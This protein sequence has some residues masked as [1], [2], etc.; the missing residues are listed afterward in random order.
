MVKHER[1]IVSP[2]TGSNENNENIHRHFESHRTLSEND[3]ISSDWY[4]EYQT[5]TVQVDRPNKMDFKRSNSQYDNHIRQ[6]REEQERVQKKTFVNWIN[7]H[8]SKRIP[9]LRI[10]DLIHDLRD[11]TKLLALLEVLSG[12][13]LP[14]EKGR[15]LRRPHFLSNANTALQFLASKRIKLVNINPADLVDGRPPVVLGLIW[16]I[17]L[18]FQIEENS[19]ALEYLGHG[20]S[21]SVSSLDSA[22]AISSPTVLSSDVKAEKWK[23]GARKTLLNWVSNA[24]PKDI[25]VEVRDFGPSWRDG[26]AF[27]ALIDSIKTNLINLAEMRK[28]STTNKQ[29]LNTAFDVAE[30]KL[31]IA[32]LLDADDVDVPKPEQKSIMTYVAQFLHKYPEPKGISRGGAS[33]LQEEY[34]EFVHWLQSRTSHFEH[35][36]QSQSLSIDFADY[37]V[38]KADVDARSN[39]FNK[40]KNL[41]T[42]HHNIA[43]LTQASWENINKLWNQHEFQL[44]YWLWLLDSNLPGDFALVGKWLAEAEKLLFYDEIPTTMNE[45]TAAI[46]SKKLEEH[47]KFFGNYDQIKELFFRVKQSSSLTTKIPFEQLKNIEQRLCEVGPKAHQRRLNLKFL[48]HKCCIIA[49]LNLIENKLRLWSGKFG[50]EDRSKQMLQQYNDFIHKNM[51]FE[52]FE[53]AFVDMKH[54]VEECRRDGNLTRQDNYDIEKFMHD[55]EDRWKRVSRD[56]K[57]CQNILGEVVANWHRWNSCSDEFEGW[58]CLAEDKIRA[59]EDERLEFFQDISLWKNKYQEMH[60]IVNFLIAICEPEIVNELRDKFQQ[61]TLR[62]DKIY[63]STKQYVHSS[64]IL[65]N[66]QEY[67]QSSEKLAAWLN[68]AESLLSKQIPC[69]TKSIADHST[70][71]QSL[72]TEIDDVEELFKQISKMIQSLLPDM[73]RSEVE[74]MMSSLKQQKEQLVRV[75]AQIPNKL[76]LFHQL[77]TQQESLEQGQK[78]VH[79]WLN[80]AEKLLQS[81]SLTANREKLQEQL[82]KHREFFSRILYY[83]SMVDTKNN[84][85]QN[86]LK[87]DS[88][89]KLLDASEIQQ[90]MG[91]LNDR[92]NYVIQNAQQWEQRLQ[93]ADNCWEHFRE[94]ERI[95]ADWI[96]K[97]EVYLTE[98]HI[99]SAKIIEERKTFFENV[100]TVWMKNLLTS[101]Q[102]LL[103]TLPMEEQQKVVEN[104][105]GLQQRWE[106]VLTSA[107]QHLIHSKFNLNE[108]NLN[109]TIKEIEREVQLEQ[110]ALNKNEDIGLISQR[111]N[112]FIT[113]K[114][115]TGQAQNYIENM[116]QLCTKYNELNPNDTSLENTMQNA[117]IKW[118]NTTRRLDELQKLLCQVPIQWQNYRSKFDT[119][120]TW[121]NTVDSALK[122]IVQEVS[123]SEEFEKERLV[124]QKICQDADA[125][126]EDMK[127]LVSTLDSLQ[128]YV[129]EMEAKEEQQKLENLIGRY[130]TLIPTIE[131]TMVKTE[132]FS[133]CYTYRKE[134]HEVVCLLEK[135]KDQTITAPQPESLENLRQMIQEQQFAINQ[136]DHQRTHIMSM[137]QRGR[138][139]SKDVHAPKFMPNEIKNLENGWNDAYNETVDKLRE[140]KSTESIW[141]EFQE[142]KH[143]I[144]NLLGNAE[145]ELRSITPLQTDPKNVSSDLKTKRELNATL[146]QASRQMIANLQDRCKELTPL[147]DQTKKPLIEKEVTE[148]EKQFFNTMEHVKDRVNYLEDYSFRWNNYKTRVAELQNWALNSAP[149]LIEAVQSQE[150]SPEERV[151]K[152]EAL[153]SIISEKMRSLD[154][155]SSDACE[156]APKEGNFSEAKRLKSEVSKLQEML[157]VINRNVNHQSMTTKE[158]LVN[159]Q[160]YQAGIQEIK[161]W[162]E[163]S[164]S[165]FSLITEKP[166]SLQ[167][168]YTLQQQARQFASQCELQKEKL[169][170]VASFNNLM[171]CKT[172]APDELDAVNSRWHSVQD[173]AKQLANRYDRLVSNWQTF[174]NDAS[175][176]EDWVVRSEQALLTRPL[177]ANSPHVDKLEKELIHLKTFNND[178]SE[179][180]AKIVSLTQSSETLVPNLGPQG[181]NATK[182]RINALRGKVGK[183][184]EANRERINVISDAII[185]RQDFNAKLANFATLMERL[186]NQA[187]Q[188]EDLAVERVEPHLQIVH[189]LLQEHSDMKN[190]FNSI[191]E[192]VKNMT[193]NASPE[194][195]GIINDSYTALVLNYQNIEDDLQQKKQALQ[196]W[197]DFL[198]WKNDIESNANHIKQQLEKATDKS[199]NIENL[200]QI[201][202]EITTNT[203]SVAAKKADANVIDNIPVV[204]LR[205]TN[206]GK[207]ITAQQITND[208]ENKFHNLELKAQ[209]QVATLSK[210]EAQ[211]GGFIKIENSLGKCLLDI[212]SNLDNIITRSPTDNIEQNISDLNALCVNLQT[213]IPL[214]EQMHN[215]GTQLMQEDISSIPAIQESMLLLNKRW[216]DIQGEIDNQLQK[217]AQLNHAVQEYSNLK[218]R[219]NTEM[220]KA[221][222]IYS[223]IEPEPK[224]EQQLIET[225][226]KSK[227]ALD[228]I[229]KSKVALDDMERRGT[230]LIKL[231]QCTQPNNID[232]EIKESETKWQQL[233]VQIA[234]NAHL[235]ETEAI[236]WNQIEEF[237][238]ELVL[239][240]DDIIAALNDAANNTLEIEYSPIRLNK[241]KTELPTYSNI[242][243]DLKEKVSELVKMNKGVEIPALTDLTNALDNKFSEAETNALKLTE[244]SSNFEDQEKE[245]RCSVKNCGDAINKIRE[246]LITTDDM[247]GDNSK[248]V[249]RLQ[250]CQALKVQLSDQESELDNL[251]MRIDEMKFTYP[252][253]AESIIPKELNNVQK[254]M[255][256]ILT[257][258]NKIESSLSHFLKKFH[259]DKIGM[260]G[261][262][263]NAQKEKIIWCIPEP[264]S[265]KFNLE[266]KKSSLADVQGSIDDC[267]IRNAEI[268]DS[269]D[270]LNNI[271]SPE[272]V[273]MIKNEIV[274]YNVELADIQQRCEKTKADLDDNIALWNEY[275]QHFEAVTNWFKEI[276]TNV[277]NESIALIN[278]NNIDNKISEL[279]A[280][281]E[282]IKNKNPDINKLEE[283]AEKIMQNNSEARVG[284]TVNHMVSR[285]KSVGKSIASLLE[286]TKTAKQAYIDFGKNEATCADWTKNARMHLNELF[287]MGSPGSGPTRQQLNLVKAFVSNLPRGQAHV[288]DLFNSAEALYPLVTSEDRENIRNRRQQ[289]RDDFDNIQDEANSLLSQV[290]SLLIHKTSIEESFA[291]VKQWLDDAKTKLGTQSE[292]YPSLI[293]KKQALQILRSQLQD[294][295]LHKNALKQLQDKAQSMADI[296]AIEKVGETMKEYDNLH[297]HLSCR[298]ADCERSVTNHESYDQITERAQEFLKKLGDQT[299]EIF[300]NDCPFEKDITEQNLE[301]LSSV[302]GERN[303]G[304]KII[305]ACK[306]QLEKVLL[307]THPSGHPVLI[308]SFENI[309]REWDIYIAQCE[310]TQNKLKEL[311]EKWA[312]ADLTIEQ[313]ENWLKKVESVPK[314]QSMKSTYETKQAYLN[315]LQKLN[316]EIISKEAE[317]A[318]LS[319]ICKDING[320]SAINSRASKL[321]TRYQA[322]KN[323]YREHIDK[324]EQYAKNHHSF[325]EDYDQFRKHLQEVI[326][327]LKENSGITGDLPILQGRQTALRN[328]A[329]QRSNDAIPFEDIID[330]G[331][332]LYVNTNPEGRELIRQQL[333]SLRAEWD[334]FSDDLNA[335]TQKIENCL[336]QFTDFA[337]GQEQLTRWLKDVEQAM[338]NH[339]EL[340]TTL[341]EKR[342]QLQNHKLMN[343]DIQNH[344]SLVDA[345]CERAQSLVNETQDESLNM[346]LNSIKQLFDNIVEKS[347]ELM[348]NLDGCVQS[349]QN[350]NAQLAHLK[351][352]LSAEK[353]KLVECEDT[354]GEKNDLKRKINILEQLKSNQNSGHRLVN[355]LLEQS[356]T[357]KKCTSPRGIDLID[358]ELKELQTEINNHIEN[359]NQNEIKLSS[360]LQSWDDFEMQLDELTK[361]CR[362]TETIFRDQQLQ[363]T[364]D[365]KTKHL[366][367]F[368]VKKEQ[369]INKQKSVD[370]FTDK[371]H[372]ILKNTG[373]ER[374]QL[375]T[376]QLS[377]RYQ[378]LTALS[379]EVV[380]RWQTIVDDHRKYNE[381]LAEV[382]NW[383]TPLEVELNSIVSKATDDTTCVQVL[384]HLVNES[385]N[386]DTLMSS[387]DAIG[388]KALQE[389]STTGREKIRTDIRD[390]HDR[391]DKLCDEIHKLQK[392]QETQ[393]HQLSSYQDLLQQ[394]L[395]W[396]KI[397][398]DTITHENISGWTSIQEIRS[399]LLKYKTMNQDILSHK[400]IIETLND[401]AN[402][403][404]NDEIN[405]TINKVNERY[406]NLNQECNNLVSRLEEALDIFQTFNDNQKQQMDYQKILWDRLNNYTDYSGNKNAIEERMAKIEE[407]ERSLDEGNQKLDDLSKHVAQIKMDAI[408]PRC[409][410]L[411]ARDLSGLKIDFDK[412][413][414][415]LQEVKFNLKNRHQQWTEYESNLDILTDWLTQAESDLKNFGLKNTFNEKQDQLSKFQNLF[416]NLNDKE[417]EFDKIADDSS[418]LIQ[419]TKE[420]RIS[421][422]A[423]QI[424]LRFQSMKNATKEICK[425]C[426]NAVSDHQQFNDK[427]KKCSEFLISAEAKYGTFFNVPQNC[428]RDDLLN[429]QNAI[430]QVLHQQNTATLLLNNVIELGEK[431]YPTT[432]FEGREA[433]REQTQ[434]L[435]QLMEKLFDKINII[436]RTIQNKLSKWT[437]FEE[438]A[439]LL[440]DWLNTLNIDENI[441]LRDTLDEKRSQLHLYRDQL[442]D[443]LLHKSDVLNLKD[444]VANMPDKNEFVVSKYD[445]IVRKYD[446]MHE[447]L[448][449]FVEQYEV[450]VSDHNLYSK[451]VLDTLDY[452]EATQNTVDLWGDLELERVLLRTNLNRLKNQRA[453]LSDEKVRIEQIR[454]LGE[455][456]IP[457]TLEPGQKLIQN[458][459][460]SSQQE[461][462]GIL[463]QIQSTIDAI[464]SKLQ[465]WDEFEKLKDDCINWIR[466]TDNKLHAI[467]LKPTLAEKKCQ[468]DELKVLQGEIRAKELEI[469]NVSEKAQL[470][471]R[472]ATTAKYSQI[473][474]LI[475]KYQQ[476]VHKVKELNT[477][478]SQFVSTHSEFENQL[479]ECTEWLQDINSKLDYCADVSTASQKDLQGKLDAVQDMIML[480]DEGFAKVQGIVEMAQPVLL[481]TAPLGHEPINKSLAQLQNDWSALAVK[482]VEIKS[483]LDQSINQYSGFVDQIKNILKS[484]DWIEKSMVDLSEFQTT[485][486]EKRSQLENI[487]S[488][489]EKV[490]V[491]K[492]DADALKAQVT[493]MLS[494]KQPNQTAYQ[495]LQTLEKFDTLAE[496]AKKLLR[497][498]ESQYRD[499]RLFI[500]AKNDLFGWIN[501]A[502][503]KLPAMKPQSL[504][505]KLSIEN[506]VAPLDAL[507]NKKAQGELLVEHLIHTGEV[508]MASTSQQGNE[509]IRNDIKTLRESFEVLFKDILNQRNKLEVTMTQ[510]REFKEEFDRISEWLQQIDILVKN[511]KIALQ[512]NRNEKQKQVDDMR[513]ILSRLEK[514]QSDIEKLK[515]S[516]APLLSSHLDTYINNQLSTLNS[517][518]SI[519]FNLAKDTLKKVENNFELHKEYDQYHENAKDW[520]E[521][522]WVTIRSCS[523]PSNSKETLQHR[524]N[525]IQDLLAKREEGQS[526][527]HSTVN[528]GEKVIRGTRSDGRDDINNQIKEIQSE[529]ERLVKKMSTAKVN[530]ETNL[531]QWADYNSSYSHLQEW[532]TEREAKLLQVCEQKVPKTRRGQ[533]NLSCGLNERR[534]NL[535]QTNNIVQDIVSFE[536]MIQSVTSKA[537]DLMQGTP[538][539]DISNKYET[540][541]KQAKD[542]Y[543]KQKEEIDKHQALIDAENEFSQWLR[544]AKDSLT[545][546]AEPTGDKE[547]LSS[548][549]NQIIVLENEIPYGKN[550]LDKIFE[551]CEIACKISEPED[552]E[553]IDEA[554]TFLQEEFDNY[555]NCV[556]QGKDCINVALVKWSEYQDQYKEA[557]NWLT[558][559]EDLIQS[560]N[561]LQDSL[562][563]KKIVLEEFQ[564]QLQVLFDWQKELDRLNL[565]AQKLLETCSDARVSNP[566]TQLTTKYNALLSL[567]KEIMR[568]LELF[569]QEHHQ[570]H[571]LYE[572]C[573]YWIEKTREKL[574]DC[575]D[576]P[577]TLTEIQIKLNTVKSL[578]Q[579]FE[580]GQNKLRY[581][582]E[583]KEKVV[584]NTEANGASKIQEDTESLKD[585]FEKLLI[586]INNVRQQLMARAA[587]LE[588]LAQLYKVIVDWLD[589]IEPIIAIDSNDFVDK[590][591]ALDKFRS[592]Q[593]DLNGY[594]EI[595]GKIQNKIN[596][597]GNL[598]QS[599][600]EKVLERFEN[601]QDRINSMIET[602]ENHVNNHEKSKQ[603]FAEIYDW[604][605]KERLEIQQC[606]DAHGD[607]TE[608]LQKLE[609]LERVDLSMPEGKILMETAIELS[610]NVKP[611]TDEEGQDAINRDIKQLG[612]D[613]NELTTM[614]ANAHS[615][616]NHC[617]TAWDKVNSK[618]DTVTK[619]IDATTDRV[620]AENEAENKT[621]D[622]LA[623]CKNIL[624]EISAYGD[625]IEELNDIC[626]NLVE[627]SAFSKIRDQTVEPQM[628][629]SKLLTDA[630]GLVA[631]IEK[632]ITDHTDF[633]NY[634]KE[635]DIWLA[636]ANETLEE[637]AGIGDENETR[638]KL[639]AITN[640]SSRLPEGKQLLNIVQ[641]AFTKAMNLTPEDKQDVL[642]SHMGDLK[643]HYLNFTE[644]I[645]NTID[646]LKSALNKWEDHKEQ[647]SN[648]E[649]WLINI[650][651][652]LQ[653]EADA[654]GELSEMKT[655]LDSLKNISKEIKQKGSDDL[656]ILRDANDV[657]RAW[658]KTSSK[659]DEVNSLQYRWEKVNTECDDRIQRLIAEINDYNAYYQKLQDA[660]KWLLQISFQLMA[661][662]SLY[663][664]NRL[665][666]QEQIDQHEI[667]MIEIQ[668]YQSN[669]DDLKAKG[670]NQIERYE[671]S[672][673]KI[674]SVIS[675]QLKNV[676]DSYDSLLSTSVQIRN[677]LQESLAKFEEYENILDS[678]QKNLEEYE[679]TF[680]D[681]DEPAITL[682]MAKDQLKSA[683]ILHNKLQAEKS[684]LALAVKA[685]E[686]ATASI[687]RPSSPVESNIP[688]IPEKELIIRGKLEDLIDQIQSI[689]SGLQS[690]VDELDQLQKQRNELQDWIKKQ[691]QNIADWVSKPL[692]LRP[693]ASKQEIIAMNDLLNAIGDKRAQLMTEMTGSFADD[694]NSDI[695]QQ[696]DKLEN[697]LMDAIALKTSGQNIIETYRQCASDLNTYFDSIIKKIDAIDIGSGLNCVQKLDA[698]ALIQ[699]ECEIDGLQKL[700]DLKQNAQKVSEVINNLD[701]QQIEEK[702]KST[703]RK[704]NDII[705]RVARKAQM[706]A[707]TNKGI[708][709]IQSEIDQLN[710]WISQQLDKLQ[711][712]QTVSSDQNLLTAYLH[713]LKA[714]SKDADVKQVLADTLKRR[715]TNIQSDLESLEKSQLDN[716]L[717]DICSKHKKL[718]DVIV[719]EMDVT[720]A[721]IQR[722]KSFET[723]V[724]K[725]KTWLRTKLVETRKQP[726][727]VPFHSKAVE[728]DIQIA[729]VNE[730]EILKSG[731]DQMNEI[732]KQVQNILKHCPNKEPL[733]IILEGLV[734]DYTDLKNE[735]A[736]TIKQL[737]VA[738]EERKL[739][740]D[741]VSKLEDWLNEIQVCTQNDVQMRSLPMLEEKLSEFEKLKKQ[742]ESMRS[743]LNGLNE[744]GK[745]ILPELN[746]VDKMKLNEQL[747]AIKDKFNK[748]IITDRIKSIEELIKKYKSSAEKLACCID[749]LNKIQQEI[750][751]LKKPIGIHTEDVKALNNTAERILRDLIDNK[752]KVSSIQIEDLPELSSTLARHDEAIPVVERQIANLR[753]AHA[754]REQYFALID[755]IDASIG[756]YAIQITDIEKSKKPIE[757]KLNQYDEMVEK[758]QEC[759]GVLA[760]VQD[761]G[762]KIAAEGTIADGN[763]ITENNQIIKHKLQNLYQQVKNQRQKYENTLAEHNKVSS[764]LS[765]LLLWLHN[766]ESICKSRPL[767]ERDPESVVPEMNKHDNFAKEVQEYLNQLQTIDEKIDADSGIP[768]CIMDMLS[769]GRSLIVNLP[770][771]LSDRRK[772]LTDSK[773]YRSTYI[774]YV[775]EF[776]N[777]IHQAEG[778]FENCKHGIDFKN[779]I[780]DID[781]FNSFF[782]ND[783]PVRDL[784]TQTVQSTVDKIWPTLQTVEQN[785]LSE[786]VRQ[787]KK[788]LDKTLNSAK[789]Q[790]SQFEKH[791][792]DWE[793]YR[794]TLSAIR[795]ILDGI[796]MRLDPADSLSNIQNNLRNISNILLDLKSKQNKLETANQRA[797]D[798]MRLADSLNHTQIYDEITDLN[799]DWDKKLNELENSIE[800]LTVLSNHW[801]DFEKRIELFQSQLNRIEEKIS[802]I[803][804]VVKSR[805]HLLDTKDIY[806]GLLAEI[807]ELET[808]YKE[809][810]SAS[811]YVLSYFNGTLQKSESQEIEQK[812]DNLNNQYTTLKTAISENNGQ[813]DKELQHFDELLE[814]ISNL[815]SQVI[816]LI[817]KI[818]DLYVY[819][820]NQDKIQ[821]ELE[822]L[823]LSVNKI[824]DEN[825]NLIQQTQDSYSKQQGFVP[826]DISEELKTLELTAENLTE[827][828]ADKEREFKRARTVR[829][830]YLNGVDYIQAWLQQAELRIQDRTLEPS[831]LKE[832]LNDIQKELASVTDKL[833]TIKQCALIITDNSQSD[834]EK[835][836][837][838]CTIDQL[839]KQIEQIRTDLEAKKHQLHDS[840]DAYTR[841]M[842]LYQNVM[843]WSSEKKEFIDISLNVTTLS[844]ARQKMNEYMNGVQSIK[845]IGKTLSEMGKELETIALVT[846]SGDLQNKLVEAENVKVEIEAILL[847]R[848]T[849]LQETY[850][851][852][853]QCDRKLKDIRVW[854]DKIS[855]TIESTQFKRKPLRDQHGLCE[856][857]LSEINGQKTKITLSVE[858]LQVHFRSGIG[859]DSKIT[860]TAYG[861]IADLERLEEIVKDKAQNLETSLSQID[862]YQKH[863]QELRRRILQEEQQLRLVMAPTYLPNDRE[864]AVSDQQMY[865]ERIKL[866]KA[867]STARIERIALI[868]QRGTPDAEPIQNT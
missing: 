689:V 673:P 706:I 53:K 404:M 41:V 702:L 802:N 36:I 321:V 174:D 262:M 743:I 657:N 175:K 517:K 848:N 399:R 376:S 780:S 618:I 739:L 141:N 5:Q 619:W 151:L 637:C 14:V 560:F 679:S 612:C 543:E 776:N 266:V 442:N 167:E 688:M 772:Y 373:A 54:V 138:D 499:H 42:T 256:V 863:I 325:N 149:Q 131:I 733:E 467:D 416:A 393:S 293:E 124:F 860:T 254:R 165:R 143:R 658:T 693:E 667:L 38:A 670:Y 184:S 142:E 556:S 570:H 89:E 590:R 278:V 639:L 753:Q 350:Y 117:S 704:Y 135:V 569:Y 503:D 240:L 420:S 37:L 445:Q 371:A 168:A 699:N 261:R 387:L 535:R 595:I 427:Y 732:N 224:G 289:P 181:L 557:F 43:A 669:I 103:K 677:R 13:K 478:W 777:W 623:R 304:N 628:K 832:I 281:H 451:A 238:S 162:I 183:L 232:D 594:N 573:Q 561:R 512:S 745:T 319:H 620:K 358:S 586:D 652:Q 579:G 352:W 377:N 335:S 312:A 545:K 111:Y 119:M 701:E 414:D 88:T 338:Q 156:L 423:Q 496:S 229:K 189:N 714:V 828:M 267:L 313:I 812:L 249:E 459:I 587:K 705:K 747:K 279:N 179:Q 810:V 807:S 98:R 609:Q 340:K 738:M 671:K 857:Y 542:L 118:L 375:L 522:A 123:T 332:K 775:K 170:A 548:K 72:A 437:G 298:V 63:A 195:S 713:K 186:R 137:L 296:E 356:I 205:D 363:S 868:V 80:E 187:A 725:F 720:S 740:E 513:N 45:E 348:T 390:M 664:T 821:T 108:E 696:L 614:L 834:R 608:I 764:D 527:I 827:T 438:C 157:S 365:D 28:S 567:A 770:K 324:Y 718:T 288:N 199:N 24:L 529:W 60:D 217:C 635:M 196:K 744:R 695:E 446:H 283:I 495:A 585:D 622:D 426:T 792:N 225:S 778:H 6:I 508:C 858:K 234:Q 152:T 643:S 230:L 198:G 368:R 791:Q 421:I 57:C 227:Q 843:K 460:D 864:K 765:A 144:I 700:D 51:V 469:D 222:K 653:I 862:E 615:N 661:H 486:P 690:T 631:K 180:L 482:M 44:Q 125:K 717:R 164:E 65:R 280:I 139:L 211:K 716:E 155:L 326:D 795:N 600:F 630:Q 163:R 384:E 192:E 73:S 844:E 9:P 686:T 97:A 17:I 767:L 453:N 147:T 422:D 476:V 768:V 606:F 523:E 306:N 544:N 692:K 329:D 867:K 122:S 405:N 793:T 430:Q 805:Q 574:N 668:K 644:N 804:F 203:V 8:L 397:N 206:T 251:R 210:I 854:I 49:F 382:N 308:N 146:Q 101:G 461:W 769:E 275:E 305:L 850:E 746:N 462:E 597:D 323:L 201:I 519:V 685:C 264:S 290:E 830:E 171:S 481:T 859:G 66:K 366:M 554:M 391:W 364:H 563:G 309:K 751:E 160:K 532:I 394:I 730:C 193:L 55:T 299:A 781:K 715:V 274:R 684:R 555:V 551:Q 741:D 212:K 311:Y 93:D 676:Q 761:K 491:E 838:Q 16:T 580:Q 105:E 492:I 537:S 779:I 501:R 360:I 23:Q 627:I 425:N 729:K 403:V 370:L 593:R 734:K 533:A 406:D 191:Y 259:M 728:D 709:S 3:G 40:L 95:V 546:Y 314:D 808:P 385:S 576:I 50:R 454:G 169:N 659:V 346:Y 386:A 253:F 541:T 754:L 294:N 342:A 245:L 154:I 182:E 826:V 67:R 774:Q 719:S 1:Q 603:A 322:L 268:S 662:N 221:E 477:R 571:T 721:A 680:E 473:T 78:D 297:Q 588:E 524:L 109:Q 133:K 632:G 242:Y 750:C 440:E 409:K 762:K 202:E 655:I 398:E 207:P 833:E 173:N 484:I 434:E 471:H 722:L 291:Q 820:D 197:S 840:L 357:V 814:T 575:Q 48:E 803:D 666:T 218:K 22:A 33:T 682:D 396:L 29:R 678:I 578:R 140:L 185:S 100:N 327:N 172:N 70:Q 129:S 341:Q 646:L 145:T 349:H 46:I 439:E 436:N 246:Q 435:S 401:K 339:T 783:R 58:L 219:F 96:Y 39:L 110:Q 11:G 120:T 76:H 428:S 300:R 660:E 811:Q 564:G 839:E 177:L 847:K 788:L 601:V 82:D 106:N 79:N 846:S 285:Y 292:L 216:D 506:S 410:E 407:I 727:T 711:E 752:N 59:S 817:E 617:I 806:Q 582:L 61:L 166:V 642:Q 759:E 214:K 315:K 269:I 81:Y 388:E 127:W 83:R 328:I 842:K 204:Y 710:S 539:S 148:L 458:Q 822:K 310:D 526:L 607:H 455:K 824:I 823:Q 270:L 829:S 796:Q 71:I 355:D 344:C 441:I 581:V 15:V 92:F 785:E 263:I 226:V 712:P 209:N 257:H 77:Y 758:I 636:N 504:A 675:T 789:H 419:N 737:S 443:I 697:D 559:T 494:S 568:R 113:N 213:K 726:N 418:D 638:Q 855:E 452:I 413:K 228:Q 56:L 516:S 400:R 112:D 472:G 819:G 333:R 215:E 756:K 841:F 447:I 31:G 852:W 853:E 7:S 510:W 801:Q 284:Q 2:V 663:I 742:R 784:I 176:L 307:E 26:V 68:K 625:S 12:E 449:G 456:V 509:L 52:E 194:D 786:E 132:V 223:T 208:L 277:K 90:Q 707:A 498:R 530:L 724:E 320:E 248:I 35:L 651:N 782:E 470:L 369:I 589:E 345:V 694:D 809:I 773:E 654:H 566:V 552:K 757:D 656:H 797:Q 836:L 540:L 708:Q 374:L 334:K 4:N 30:N 457:N 584:L 691:E 825:H 94:D 672:S 359:V 126:R 787:Y 75:R 592:L 464:E 32:R 851:E 736:T 330:R 583:L 649:K 153:Q 665:Q 116:K 104:V 735:V 648:F 303:Q 239:W 723:D 19:R 547:T 550:K 336:L 128:P 353:Q 463:S 521:K 130:K 815:N 272:N 572:E 20:I 161:P 271:E 64:D 433:I 237:K 511:H 383:I 392:K 412:F 650:E 21:G 489:E 558:K 91:Q 372:D 647:V 616:L 831:Q 380:N 502:R 698:I 687:S 286:R 565:L 514:G 731:T 475:P 354:Y 431:L 343:E 538:A 562:E 766:N 34:D 107:P 337:Q 749:T 760:S 531:L 479:C 121:M 302:I 755:Q 265:D 287:R 411:M 260:L 845:P 621:S 488:M 596:E 200:K 490:R 813:V 134:V 528:T 351:D 178:I 549:L 536:P 800:T 444:I 236:I 99:Q 47:K 640:L 602:L 520:I 188:V 231:L 816:D 362:A 633:L 604:I 474:D 605:R 402:V 316:E 448:Q 641:E 301:V 483:M 790:R 233:Q 629:Y 395:A 331:E 361:W 85:L 518:F 505:D 255:D 158:D 500:E 18:Y 534:A 136:L 379:K 485:M 282:D 611:L 415:T 247:S 497:E 798:L 591:S 115:L 258:A 837:I 624:A 150:I 25:G 276:E 367:A 190:L 69:T 507:L 674:R 273:E 480:K 599:D 27:L 799:S 681:L 865:H 62:F 243:S 381:K 465:Q 318:S 626:E 703:D 244:I 86:L 598:N 818:T 645:K 835:K 417:S 487:K 317:F 794:D 378:L 84:V 634:K 424:S 553:I 408:S 866:L 763:K 771:E 252:T 748:P 87:F 102:N 10:D 429:Q 856:K 861:I 295:I 577:N 683:Q 389:T 114:G 250:L 468:I 347:Q 466:I 235:F 220:V 74:N 432:A 241:Y 159:W 515:T 613:W 610:Q 450:F 525:Q 493:E 849:L